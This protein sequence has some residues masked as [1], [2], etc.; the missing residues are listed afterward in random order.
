MSLR[1]DLDDR[2]W[3]VVPNRFPFGDHLTPEAWAGSIVARNAD[4]R[5]TA[6]PAVDVRAHDVARAAL[7]A[8]SG[9]DEPGLLFWPTPR[10]AAALF[11]LEIADPLPWGTDPLT[12][13]LGDLPLGLPPAVEDLH[14]PGLGRGIVVRAVLPAGAGEPAVALLGALIDTPALAIRITSEPTTT[15]MAGLADAPLRELLL[16]LRSVPEPEAEPEAE[17]EPGRPADP[18]AAVD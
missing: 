7:E 11:H 2:F 3:A 18:G 8:V 14:V 6:D 17:P 10:P 13:L 9:D 5:G 12:V 16:G 15:T 4:S 1:F